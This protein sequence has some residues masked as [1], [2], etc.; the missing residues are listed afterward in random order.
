MAHECGAALI[1]HARPV[2]QDRSAQNKGTLVPPQASPAPDPL[3]DRH[4]SYGSAPRPEVRGS[5]ADANPNR[6]NRKAIG[7]KNEEHQKKLGRLSPSVPHLAKWGRQYCRSKGKEI[8][9]RATQG[10]HRARGPN[11]VLDPKPRGAE[12]CLVSHTATWPGQ[13]SR[14]DR[15]HVWMSERIGFTSKRAGI[16]ED[17]L[18]TERRLQYD[19]VT[20]GSSIPWAE[21]AAS[22]LFKGNEGNTLGRRLRA[23]RCRHRMASGPTDE[24]QLSRTGLD[25]WLGPS[26]PI[27]YR[28]RCDRVRACWRGLPNAV[29]GRQKRALTKNGEAGRVSAGAG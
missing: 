15:S 14:Q 7:W 1:E 19:R 20:P 22:A 16:G 4:W 28:Q 8:G 10:P 18:S 29:Q 2:P 6:S 27:Q 26:H 25:C 23:E 9:L 3:E 13:T 17:S 24:D 21:I 12:A 11:L 5:G